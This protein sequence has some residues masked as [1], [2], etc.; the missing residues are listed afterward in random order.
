[1]KKFT[2]V[3]MYMLKALQRRCHPGAPHVQHRATAWVKLVLAEDMRLV[4][5]AIVELG[6]LGAK[7]PPP[8]YPR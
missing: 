8:G 2:G 7:P 4:I 6:E 1:M 3:A 5:K